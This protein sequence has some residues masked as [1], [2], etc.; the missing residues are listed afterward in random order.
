MNKA[1]VLR[2]VNIALF[3]SFIIQTITAS[4]MLFRINTP[5]LQL[6]SEVH[7]YNGIFLIIAVITHIVLNW[8]WIKANFFKKR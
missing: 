3:F 1:V 7:E 2:I 6:I 4:V 5:Y 8:G